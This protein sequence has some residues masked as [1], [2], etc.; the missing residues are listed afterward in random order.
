MH[1]AALGVACATALL[2][3]ETP[4]P[5]APQLEVLVREADPV[6]P[7]LGGREPSDEDE[8]VL[9]FSDRTFSLRVTAEETAGFRGLPQAEVT[10]FGATPAS[11]MVTLVDT[12]D[13]PT[14]LTADIT[15]TALPS[16]VT[17]VRVRAL[18]QERLVTVRPQAVRMALDVSVEERRLPQIDG[19]TPR[20][21]GA[22]PSDAGIANPD[23]G[24]AVLDAGVAPPPTG[25]I[26]LMAALVTCRGAPDPDTDGG[27]FEPHLP[28]R[29]VTFSTLPSTEPNP[30]TTMT[31]DEG[32][33]RSWVVA[34]GASNFT[35]IARSGSFEGRWPE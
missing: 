11:R 21:A 31:D 25:A 5:Q 14:D 17:M 24:D 12:D 35:V 16:E 18:A 19:G 32:V 6:R 26:L 2:A 10:V 4:A 27:V 9:V 30:A 22:M 34:P 3:C 7:C 28:R 23:A 29:S 13:P 20:D 8:D 1:R 33:A 15:L